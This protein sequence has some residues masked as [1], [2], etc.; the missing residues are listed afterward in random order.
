MATCAFTTASVV[1]VPGNTPTMVAAL[2]SVLRCARMPSGVVFVLGVVGLAAAFGMQMRL[3]M[4]WRT[5]TTATVAVTGITTMVK[6]AKAVDED[7][8]A[9]VDA[10]FDTLGHR[11]A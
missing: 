7:T 6:R 5:T 11:H 10:N 8:I 9:A 4:T 2:S 1:D 3:E